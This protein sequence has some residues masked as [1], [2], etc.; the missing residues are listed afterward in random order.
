MKLWWDQIPRSKEMNK[1]D[2]LRTQFFMSNI[3]YSM[4]F[5]TIAYGLNVSYMEL[6]IAN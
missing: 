1:Q 2:L 5:R 4:T 6:W 3:I